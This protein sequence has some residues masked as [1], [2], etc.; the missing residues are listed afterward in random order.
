VKDKFEI[1]K[2]A[3]IQ[4][5]DGCGFIVSAGE[6]RYVVTAALFIPLVLMAAMSPARAEQDSGLQM[7]VFSKKVHVC[8]DREAL[9]VAPKPVDLETAVVAIMARCSKQLLEMRNFLYT[10]IPNFT[11]STDFWERDIEPSWT[12]EARKAVALARTRDMPPPKPKSGPVPPRND[13]NQI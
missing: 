5:D 2:R 11:P 12:K 10:G 4:V 6:S 3:V 9:A 1:A 8:L 13:K 7:G